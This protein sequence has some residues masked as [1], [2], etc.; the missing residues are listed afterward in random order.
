[1]AKRV[2][3][4]FHFQDVIDFRANVVRKHNFL[5]GVEA[6]AYYDHSIWEEAKKNSPLALKRLIN[7]ELGGW[8]THSVHG[9]ISTAGKKYNGLPGS[10]KLP[11]GLLRHEDRL[12]HSKF[13]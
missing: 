13:G 8:Q 7:G 12:T 3:F 1:M 6:A 10:T 11:N 9:F 4:A 2:Y 5:G